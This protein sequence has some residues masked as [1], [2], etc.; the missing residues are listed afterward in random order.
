MDANIMM[1]GGSHLLQTVAPEIMLLPVTAIAGA[2]LTRST[3]KSVV[4]Y[5]LGGGRTGSVTI[6]ASLFVTTFACLWLLDM[7]LATGGLGLASAIGAGVFVL[8]LGFFFAPMYL[9]S[10]TITVPQFVTLRFDEATARLWSG[11]TIAFYVAVKIPLVLML[12]T[13]TI[14]RTLGWNVVTPVALMV[15]VVMIGLYTVVGGFSAV[16]RTQFIEAVVLFVGSLTIMILLALF[17]EAA[18]HLH[19]GP[20]IQG[21]ASEMSWP[22]IAFGIPVVLAWHWFADQYVLQRILGARDLHTAQRGTVLTAVLILAQLLIIGTVAAQLSTPITDPYAGFT[23][24]EM[25]MGIAAVIFLALV[26]AT[27]SSDF[28][29]TATLFTLD[30]YRA[31]YPDAREESLVLVGRLSTTM[32]VVL[33]ILAVS[34]VSLVDE[35]VVSMLRQVQLHLAPPIVA[36]FLIGIYWDRMNSKGAL[37]AL[38]S[39]EVFGILH[40]GMSHSRGESVLGPGVF[41]GIAFFASALV[42]IVVSLATAAPSAETSMYMSILRRKQG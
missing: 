30:F 34:T 13:W 4:E 38:V 11:I 36:V 15:V 16:V 14:E 35:G 19:F 42:L 18:G 8:M 21:I 10:R 31:A 26:M 41:A 37:W 7:S 25:I 23:S 3:E 5:F 27:L 40:F 17:P 33:T 12:A 29:S 24:A 2:S 28:H 6:G 1:V 39:G 32:I 9:K 20:S 22:V